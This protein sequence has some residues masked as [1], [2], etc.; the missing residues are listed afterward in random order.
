MIENLIK[1]VALFLDHTKIPYIIIGGQ[2]VLLYGRPRM[3]QDIDIT[4]GVDID[5]Y[6]A[7]DNLCKKLQLKI[8]PD[9]PIKFVKDTRVLPVEDNK[10]KLRIDFIFSNTPYEKGAI[11]HAR[12]VKMKGYPV[13]FASIEDL[14]IHKL[15]AG[16][17]VDLEDVKG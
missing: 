3:T 5:R 16:R 13:K 6:E 12:R 2:A 7:I 15:F 17:A 11:R 10:T 1:K 8:L 4:L 9:K 14:I